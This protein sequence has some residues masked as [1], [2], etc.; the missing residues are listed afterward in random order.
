M[1]YRD[2]WVGADHVHRFVEDLDGETGIVTYKDE[3]NSSVLPGVEAV[4][5]SCRN[6]KAI[7]QIVNKASDHLT[8]IF[9]RSA[10]GY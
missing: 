10:F 5:F 3:P 8:L 6:L 4:Y 2:A 7:L 1:L 9:Q